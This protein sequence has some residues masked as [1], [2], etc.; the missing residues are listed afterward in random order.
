MSTVLNVFMGEPWS[1]DRDWIVAEARTLIR[2]N[3][4]QIV[5]CPNLATFPTPL[6]VSA[7]ARLVTPS[8]KRTPVSPARSFR[9]AYSSPARAYSRTAFVHISLRRRSSG[10]FQATM[11]N[12]GTE[13]EGSSPVE[14][15][16]HL[17]A[18]IAKWRKVES[19]RLDC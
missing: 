13:P 6:T 12:D 11:L 5:N 19:S 7:P 8:L 9:C 2:R 10:I 15:Q 4:L 3:L 16:K 1:D 18:E 17:S 14:F